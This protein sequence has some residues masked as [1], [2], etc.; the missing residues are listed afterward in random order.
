M[1]SIWSLQPFEEMHQTSGE[2]AQSANRVV[3]AADSAEVSAQ[4]GKMVVEGTQKAM[5]QLMAYISSA[6]PRLRHWPKTVT[7]SVK[8][9]K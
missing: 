9:W 8:Y 5:S 3:S 4:Q 2:V 6:K 7:A 1:R